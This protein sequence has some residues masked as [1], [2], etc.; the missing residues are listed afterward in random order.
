MYDI[1][2]YI[3]ELY[4]KFFIVLPFILRYIIQPGFVIAVSIMM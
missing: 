3:Y 1:C 2:I 4:F